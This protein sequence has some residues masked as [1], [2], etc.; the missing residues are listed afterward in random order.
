MQKLDYIIGSREKPIVLQFSEDRSAA[1]SSTTTVGGLIRR[2]EQSG[3]VVK[4]TL[5]HF[6]ELWHSEYLNA[7]RE[8][9]QYN[10]RRR[11]STT[12]TPKIGDIVI[13]TEDKLPRGQWPYGIITKLLQSKDGCI[14]S[15]EVRG[16]NGKLLT[17]SL[18]HLFHWFLRVKPNDENVD[19]TQNMDSTTTLRTLPSR[20]AK[21]AYKFIS[22]H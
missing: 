13:I 21:T 6:W 3:T 17:R 18:P 5:D 22:S 16:S 10:S 12:S 11:R 14:R 2:A 9:Q 8:R 20:T 19:A 4:D 15:A 1:S 7:L